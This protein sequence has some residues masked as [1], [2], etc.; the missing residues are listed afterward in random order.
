[1]KFPINKDK[2]CK[3]AYF[4]ERKGTIGSLEILWFFL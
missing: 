3:G 1:M 2:Y 4:K